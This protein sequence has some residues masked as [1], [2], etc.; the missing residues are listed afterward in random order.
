LE[1]A[2]PTATEVAQ[3]LKLYEERYRPVDIADRLELP[4]RIVMAAIHAIKAKPKARV[5][6]K[7]ARRHVFVRDHRVKAL[8]DFPLRRRDEV[9]IDVARR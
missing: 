8:R 3:V 9:G 4:D 5:V 2:K 7:M 1:Y 6:G